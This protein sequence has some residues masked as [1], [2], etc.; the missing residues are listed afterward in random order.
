MEIYKEGSQT[1]YADVRVRDGRHLG[2]PLYY[3]TPLTGITYQDGIN[4]SKEINPINYKSIIITPLDKTI[5]SKQQSNEPN[6]GEGVTITVGDKKIT[7]NNYYLSYSDNGITTNINLSILFGFTLL[8]LLSVTWLAFQKRSR[9]SKT[10]LKPKKPNDITDKNII[11]DNEK[12]GNAHFAQG[13]YEEALAAYNNAIDI[14]SSDATAWHKKGEAHEKLAEESY[15][16]AREL[17][18]MDYS[19]K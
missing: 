16:K 18:Y 10:K 9:T 15:A 3:Y 17:G 12:E 5:L 14:K 11:E 8:S 1:L 19:I 7:I 4:G 13:N 2:G 6:T